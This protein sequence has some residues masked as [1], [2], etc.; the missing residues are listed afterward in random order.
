MTSEL[1]AFRSVNFIWTRQL[2]S[3]WHD[4]PYHVPSIHQRVLDELAEYFLANTRDQDPENE[5]LGRIIVGPAGLGK[6]H[7]IGELRRKVWESEGAFILLDLVGIKD[8][9]S[10]VALGYLNSL[11]IRLP[12]GRTQYDLL[13]L[14]LASL[15]A[16][17]SQLTDIAVRLRGRPR[18]LISELVR[19]FVNGLLRQ[20]REA[21]LKYQDV[22][23]ALVLLISDDLECASIAHAWLQGMDLDPDEVR[24][25]GFVIVKKQPIEIVRGISWLLSLAGPTLLAVDQIDAIISEANVRSNGRDDE[26]QAREA[27][28]IIEAMANGLMDL[29]EIKHRA[30][31]V[32]SSLEASWRVLE[33]KATAAVKDRYVAPTILAAINQP[34]AAQS[35]VRARVQQ[36]YSACGFTPPYETWPFS[37]MAFETVIGF[38]PRQLLKA[39][40]DHRQRCLANNTVFECRSFD[41]APAAPA[42]APTLG[43]LDEIFARELKVAEIDGLLD[44]NNEDQLRNLLTDVLQIYVDHLALP[45]DVD[46]VVQPDPDQKRPSLHGRLSF[47]FRNE[48]DREQH[49]CF[50][51]LAHANAIAFQSRLRAAMTASGVDRALKFRH[52]FV[53]RRAA[54]PSGAKTRE[55]VAK[56]HHADGKFIVPLEQDLRTLVALRAMEERNLDGFS[57]GGA[58]AV[59]RHP[60][61]QVCGPVSALIPGNAS[62]PGKEASASLPTEPRAGAKPTGGWLDAPAAPSTASGTNR[63]S[64]SNESGLARHPARS[65]IRTRCGGR[66]GDAFRR[67]APAACRHP[68]R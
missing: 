23:R 42:S 9:W 13:I 44:Q 25:L 49:F 6:T 2:K 40:E 48:G 28:S 43:G 41:D 22:V 61:L 34:G 46:A 38:S 19:V 62:P 64:P 35:L 59:V 10:S 53:L 27:Q 66:A 56:F 54:P 67:L 26:Q 51:I 37:P 21:T 29:H 32:V 65:S 14:R 15:L 55:L 57:A 1:E 47:I 11:Q 3:I 24:D 36:A 68:G 8:F 30:V 16:L 52:L 20:N 50:R 4:Q 7:L 17:Q 5:P 18:E 12:D 31:T 33:Q 60:T 39:C 58:K 63:R 45:E